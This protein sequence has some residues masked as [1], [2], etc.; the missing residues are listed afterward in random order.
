VKSQAPNSNLQRNSQFQATKVR[1]I[2]WEF[3]ISNFSGF[4]P[5]KLRRTDVP[6]VR[7]KIAQRFNG[8]I[9]PKGRL[10]DMADG[11]ASTILTGLEVPRI[12]IPPF[13]L[14]AIIKM[15]FRDEK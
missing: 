7:L 14:R 11:L 1:G 15:S 13:K 4:L 2:E 8:K 5:A 6:K 12:K 10:K 3:G 9:V